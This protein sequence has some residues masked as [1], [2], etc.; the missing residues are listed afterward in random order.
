MN[1]LDETMMMIMMIMMIMAVVV[2]SSS[3]CWQDSCID[4]MTY[5]PSKLGHSDLVFGV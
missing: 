1:I 2:V 3:C 5:K 4:Q